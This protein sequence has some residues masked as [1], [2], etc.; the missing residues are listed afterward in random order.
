MRPLVALHDQHPQRTVCDYI[1]LVDCSLS[2]ERDI[3]TGTFK[4]AQI[5]ANSNFQRQNGLIIVVISTAARTSFVREEK[6]VERAK[7]AKMAVGTWHHAR[8]GVISSFATDG[9]TSAAPVA[10]CGRFIGYRFVPT[11]LGTSH[12]FGCGQIESRTNFVF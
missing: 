2:V 7:L 9:I 4:R 12:G 8:T 5:T 1:V 6:R 11:D 3:D 10:S